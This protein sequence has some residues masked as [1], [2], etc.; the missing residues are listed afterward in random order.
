V[1]CFPCGLTPACYAT[2][3]RL[4]FLRGLFRGNNG[5]AVFSLRSVH[6]LYSSDVAGSQYEYGTE[7]RRVTRIVMARDA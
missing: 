3:G 7:F 6:G 5:K 2:M 1:I 4:R